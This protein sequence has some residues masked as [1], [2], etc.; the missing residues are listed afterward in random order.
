MPNNLINRYHELK[1]SYKV[2]SKRRIVHRFKLL[3]GDGRYIQKLKDFRWE[4][5]NVECPY[6]TMDY[7]R[8]FKEGDRFK[9]GF[10]KKIFSIKVNTPFQGSRL[11]LATWCQA[12]KLLQQDKNISSVKLSKE[13]NITQ[14]T[15]WFMMRR[16]KTF[17]GGR[18][19]EM[20]VVI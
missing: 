16:L 8:E 1:D 4:K 6:C 20:D 19:L 13:L 2:S 5:N 11:P 7:V 10:C 14:K 18:Y 17:E 15:A 9:C 3:T 12:I